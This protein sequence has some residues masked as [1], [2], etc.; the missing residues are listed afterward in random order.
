MD[1]V[2]FFEL[3]ENFLKTKQPHSPEDG[4][5]LAVVNPSLL[6]INSA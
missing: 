1:T 6:L 2:R 4:M 5:S 3:S